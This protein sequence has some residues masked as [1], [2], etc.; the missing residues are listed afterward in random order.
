MIAGDEVTPNSSSMRGKRKQSMLG[1]LVGDV[2]NPRDAIKAT[3][4]KE[5]KKKARIQKFQT[6]TLSAQKKKCQQESKFMF[7]L[8]AFTESELHEMFKDF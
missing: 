5:L 4:I 3:Q 8:I 1:S 7:F 2:M 6:I